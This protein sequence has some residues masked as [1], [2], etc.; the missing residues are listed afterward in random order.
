L[1]PRSGRN[2]GPAL[3]NG[4]SRICARL[5]ALQSGLAL[6]TAATLTAFNSEGYT[7]FILA[8]VALSTVVGVGLNVLLWH[9]PSR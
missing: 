4:P 3:P 9:S 8:L 2:P 1:R 6:T 5:M 7:H